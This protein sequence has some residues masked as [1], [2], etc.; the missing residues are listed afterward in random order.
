MDLGRYLVGKIPERER[1]VETDDP[2]KTTFT[3]HDHVEIRNHLGVREAED[4][5]REL[6]QHAFIPERVQISPVDAELHRILG[7]KNAARAVGYAP[8]CVS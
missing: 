6:D 5:A 1:G 2:L 7:P 8:Q 4:P 3:Y